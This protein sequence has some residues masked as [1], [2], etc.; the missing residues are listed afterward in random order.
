MNKKSI[1]DI[2]KKFGLYKPIRKIYNSI[3]RYNKQ[4]EIIVSGQNIKFWTPTFYL[5]DYVKDFAGEK[6]LVEKF[7][8]R[9]KDKNTLWDIGANIGF[10][11]IL[12][13]K[14]MSSKSKVIAFEPEKDTFN[15]LKKNIELNQVKNITAYEFALGD[16][17]GK[18]LIYSSDTPNFGAHSFVQRTDFLLKKQGTEI[19]IKTADSLIEE[20]KVDIPDVIK[21][22]VEGAEILVLR[23]MKK[24]LKNPDLKIILCEVHSNLL[25]L[26]NSSEEEVKEIIL[27]ENFKIDYTVNRG[28]QFQYIFMR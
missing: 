2:L 18:Q 14:E 21:I 24:L 9:L 13:A 26:F 16:T 11:S 27:N 19:K 20:S 22:D 25:P 28:T 3:F 10:Y 4:T 6:E 8:P 1:S 5:D 23:G 17:K 12:A 7:L 15:L